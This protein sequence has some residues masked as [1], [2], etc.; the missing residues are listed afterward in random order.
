M[1]SDCRR[2]PTASSEDWASRAGDAGSFWSDRSSLVSVR[3][4]VR[5]VSPAATCVETRRRRV[6]PQWDAASAGFF[7]LW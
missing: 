7:D 3:V 4:L 2:E 5:I 6:M 1:D